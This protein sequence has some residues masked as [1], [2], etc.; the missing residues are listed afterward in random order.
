[1]DETLDADATLVLNEIILSIENS[2]PAAQ[3]PECPKPKCETCAPCAPCEKCAEAVACPECQ[4][5]EQSI[6]ETEFEDI[7]EGPTAGDEAIKLL[8]TDWEEPEIPENA[9]NVTF[10]DLPVVNNFGKFQRDRENYDTSRR[11]YEPR[12]LVCDELSESLPKVQ[13]RYWMEDCDDVPNYPKEVLSYIN[14]GLPKSVIEKIEKTGMN[15]TVS[16]KLATPYVLLAKN[17]FDFDAEDANLMRMVREA[18]AQNADIISGSFVD[19]HGHWTSNCGHVHVSNYTLDIWDGYYKSISSIMHCDISS[20]PL[21]VRKELLQ[22][23]GAEKTEKLAKWPDRLE[24]LLKLQ[25]DRVR[26]V[27][28]PDCMFYQTEISSKVERSDL[29]RLSRKFK[30]TNF[31]IDSMEDNVEF[32]CNEANIDCHQ[33]YGNQALA[34]D[35]FIKLPSLKKLNCLDVFKIK[36]RAKATLLSHRSNRDDAGAVSRV[37]GA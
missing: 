29:M 27:H 1:M 7:E 8:I 23:L 18:E 25:R 11:G 36:N 15:K 30:L 17:L 26:F 35:R 12:R 13:T 14:F 20:G 19:E 21:M 34:Q 3:C 33:Q 2:R 9:V 6:C 24:V 5:C 31:N 32:T 10:E 22:E 16:K 4:I 37:Q 28:C